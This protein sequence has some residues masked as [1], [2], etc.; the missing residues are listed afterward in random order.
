MNKNVKLALTTAIAVV[1]VMIAY[2]ILFIRT[3]NYEIGGVTIPARYNILTKKATPIK[4]Y[5]GQAPKIAI[6]NN[7]IAGTG[8]NSAEVASAQIR[9]A[10]FEKWIKNQSEYT[11]WESN[12]E[13]FEKAQKEFLEFMSKSGMKVRV[14]Q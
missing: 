14:I 13:L 3:V 12:P 9:W 10:L 4:N 2:K 6:E 7:A 1:G 5:K 11:G 8:L